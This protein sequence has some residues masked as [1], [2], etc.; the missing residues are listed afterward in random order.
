MLKNVNKNVDSKNDCILIVNSPGN[1]EKVKSVKIWNA[2]RFCVSSLRRGHANLLCIVPILVYVL[3]RLARILLLRTSP[4]RESL[5]EQ[6][7][8]ILEKFLFNQ[9]IRDICESDVTLVSWDCTAIIASLP[10]HS[11]S[12]ISPDLTGKYFCSSSADYV[13]VTYL[14]D[15]CIVN[16]SYFTATTYTGQAF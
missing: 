1:G 5:L 13:I 4:Y 12:T 3:P 14:H 6:N 8:S 11:F 16:W 15:Y 9:I 2:S 10:I 7:N